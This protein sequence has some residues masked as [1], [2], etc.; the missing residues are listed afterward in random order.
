M[1][2]ASSRRH[3]SLLH[4]LTTFL[5]NKDPLL[6]PDFLTPYPVANG[7]S[8]M[9]FLF[10]FFRV[11]FLFVSDRC[12]SSTMGSVVSTWKGLSHF[13][14][15]SSWPPP[16]RWREKRAD[17]QGKV[18]SGTTWLHRPSAVN[19][20]WTFYL[21]RTPG[22]SSRLGWTD[23]ASWEVPELRSSRAESMSCPTAHPIAPARFIPSS[24]PDRLPSQPEL[25]AL[26]SPLW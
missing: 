12:W 19:G 11:F 20:P 17:Q 24:T 13:K 8:Y 16:C 9:P 25:P 1:V 15:S 3:S 7:L 21:S 14:I 26:S 10:S 6:S 22:Q 23:T 4:A 18:N 5:S 2:K